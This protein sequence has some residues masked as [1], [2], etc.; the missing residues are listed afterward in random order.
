MLRS[1][2]MIGLS[3]STAVRWSATFHVRHMSGKDMV[4]HGIDGCLAG[5]DWCVGVTSGSWQ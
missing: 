2:E 4:T 3:Y 5:F 1:S